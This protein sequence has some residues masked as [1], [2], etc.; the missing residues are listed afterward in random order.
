MVGI[1]KNASE[2]KVPKDFFNLG[3]D[4]A[5]EER[6]ETEGTVK[7]DAE[8]TES[9]D[10][11]SSPPPTKTVASSQEEALPEGFFD[12]PLLDAKVRNTVKL[13]SWIL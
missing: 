4:V 5:V 3:S 13:L 6:N 10:A 1:L 8:D 9:E 12:D 11:E 7:E 2:P